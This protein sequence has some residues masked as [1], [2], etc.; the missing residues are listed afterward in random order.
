MKWSKDIHNAKV[1]FI[2]YSP[3][4]FWGCPLSLNHHHGAKSSSW[5]IW[6]SWETFTTDSSGVD[7]LFIGSWAQLLTPNVFPPFWGQ[8]VKLLFHEFCI[9]LFIE[10][11]GLSKKIFFSKSWPQWRSTTSIYKKS[12]PG[13]GRVVESWLWDT[14]RHINFICFLIVLV[15]NILIDFCKVY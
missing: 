12:I 8:I 1:S 11:C 13:L 2:F 14:L 15:K 4:I 3:L 10:L 6:P 9:Q 5:Y 7:F